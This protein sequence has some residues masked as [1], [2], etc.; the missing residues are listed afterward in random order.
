[1]QRII[2][3]QRLIHV[4]E[5]DLVH[6]VGRVHESRRQIKHLERHWIVHVAIPVEELSC[7]SGTLDKL[8][9]Y[10]SVQ[11]AVFVIDGNTVD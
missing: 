4:P 8:V 6:K 5:G 7:P 10:I 2:R 9:K 1:M 3:G 11:S